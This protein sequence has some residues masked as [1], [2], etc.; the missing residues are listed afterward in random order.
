MHHSNLATLADQMRVLDLWSLN[1]GGR[2]NVSRNDIA[3]IA[4][5]HRFEVISQTVMDWGVRDMDCISVL[6]KI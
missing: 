2:S 4:K 5:H 3:F 6:R 1:V